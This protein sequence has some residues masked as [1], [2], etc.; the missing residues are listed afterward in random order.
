MSDYKKY[1][2][3]WELHI[4]NRAFAF[5]LKHGSFHGSFNLGRICDFSFK[6][7]NIY[8]WDAQDS[9]I[10][11]IPEIVMGVFVSQGIPEKPWNIMFFFSI[12]HANF[13]S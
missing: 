5:C 3:G 2:A 10:P 12:R 8:F 11:E 6:S 4:P 7:L 1:S 9:G 13:L